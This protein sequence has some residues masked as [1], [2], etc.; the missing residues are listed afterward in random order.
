MKKLFFILLLLTSTCAFAQDKIITRNSSVIEAKVIEIGSDVI[1]YKRFSNQNGPLY[2]IPKKDVYTIW[3][4]NGE[5]EKIDNP[6][7]T[8]Q[9]PQETVEEHRLNAGTQIPIQNINYVRASDLK[10]GQSVNFRTARD[11]KVDGIDFLPYGTNIKGVVYEAKKSSG[12]G[13]KGRLGIRIDKIEL[14]NG[15]TIPLINGDVY[16]TGKNRTPLSVILFLFVTWPACFICGSK[17]E[18]PAGYEIVANVAEN[19]TFK[20]VNGDYYPTIKPTPL[21]LNSTNTDQQGVSLPRRGTI[22]KTNSTI[23][24]AIIES[25][26]NNQINYKKASKP[27]GTIYTIS[28]TKV[29]RI[30]YK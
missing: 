24:D 22:V 2:S 7:P 27:N 23:I 17:A 5:E 28:K 12:F 13:T 14:P 18:L 11:I 3:Y 15:L 8:T 20:N 21:P 19:V 25:V 30:D 4:E 16:V 9:E 10:V 26:N 29:S 6:T 1:K